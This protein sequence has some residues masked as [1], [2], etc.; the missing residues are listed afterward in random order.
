MACSVRNP[1]ATAPYACD[2]VAMN[3]RASI[4]GPASTTTQAVV[5]A[6][7]T[8]ALALLIGLGLKQGAD[9]AV[10]TALL[11]AVAVLM[12]GLKRRDTTRQ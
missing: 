10:F 3:L 5:G 9:S 11:V 1:P 6:V 2:D 12:I 7:V 8:F 4:F